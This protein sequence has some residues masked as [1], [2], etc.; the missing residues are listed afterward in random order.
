MS[1]NNQMDNNEGTK[2]STI[3]MGGVAFLILVSIVIAV[4]FF[5]IYEKNQDAIAAND[6]Y[7]AEDKWIPANTTL[8]MGNF[9]VTLSQFNPNA[10]EAVQ[11][12]NEGNPA[13]EDDSIYM[14]IWAELACE[15]SKCQGGEAAIYLIDKEEDEEW[16]SI[17]VS[18]DPD[19]TELVATQG[20]TIEGWV[21]FLIPIE[22]NITHLKVVKAGGP[23][24]F[25]ELPTE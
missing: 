6:G 24:L 10:N 1:L 21:A 3:V 5:A 12:L 17:E 7:G 16:T 4:T 9:D 19:F 25:A 8:K 22:A 2:F 11:A 18:L 15:K 14:L 23:V 20:E 13:A